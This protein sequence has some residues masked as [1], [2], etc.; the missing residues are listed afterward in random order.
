MY[1]QL[2]K[3]NKAVKLAEDILRLSRNTLLV[4]LRFLDM[5]LSML[6][7]HVVWESTL[8]TDGKELYYNPR[9]LLASYKAEKEMPVRNYLHVVMHCVFRHMFTGPSIY[10]TYWDLACDVAVECVI[11]ELGLSA[12]AS[13]RE[14]LQQDY[15][16]ELKGKLKTVTAEK[17]YSYLVQTQPKP[18][19]VADLRKLFCADNHSIWYMT[20]DEKA[21]SLGLSGNSTK[22]NNDNSGS[23]GNGNENTEGGEK[24]NN[25]I[26]ESRQALAEAWKGISERMQ[27]DMETFSKQKGDAAGGMMQNLREVNREKYD[28]TAFLKKFAVMGEVMKINDD[29]FD[30]IFYTYGLKLY[31][32]VPLVE[33]LEYKDVK[34]IREFVIAID[35]SGSTSGELVQKFVQ[36]TYN[37]LKSTE[38]FF[39]KINVHIIQ[40]DAEVQ[41]DRRI[42]CR[43]DFETYLKTMKLRGFGGTDFRPV[44]RYVDDLIRAGEFTNLKGMIYFTDGQGVFPDHPPAYDAA[45]VFVNDDYVSPDV[46]VWAIKLVLQREEL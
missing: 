8:L 5:A 40:C 24:Q 28:Y 37:I 42:T 10:R 36:K 2:E 25:D 21:A 19:A 11:S 35:T 31:K 16:N 18:T 30:Y 32:K 6:S 26:T 43:K 1:E 45:F 20:S 33:P 12:A 46:P 4:N 7:P 13:S 38:S 39:S 29:E 22:D 41:E 14:K 23:G 15:L 3:M 9:H 17:V 34:R 27:T 44:F